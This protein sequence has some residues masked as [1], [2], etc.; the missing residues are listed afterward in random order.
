MKPK[1]ITSIVT[2]AALAASACV[3]TLQDRVKNALDELKS[4][5]LC[6][7]PIDILFRRILDYGAVEWDQRRAEGEIVGERLK[8]YKTIS[9]PNTSHQT[10]K[11]VD[12]RVYECVSMHAHYIILENE[13]FV[14][15]REVKDIELAVVYSDIN[16]NGVKIPKTVLLVGRNNGDRCFD[17]ARAYWSNKIKEGNEDLCTA[18]LDTGYIFSDVKLDQRMHDNFKDA[19]GLAKDILER[20]FLGDSE[21]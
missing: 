3:N 13:Y 20:G 11:D 16:A 9:M 18:M 17:G 19:N 14:S 21:Q 2:V 12:S 15:K 1:K 4:D 5:E 6:T 7:E 10:R 8:I